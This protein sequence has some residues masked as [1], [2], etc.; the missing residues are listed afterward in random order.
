MKKQK[1]AQPKHFNWIQKFSEEKRKSLQD[2]GQSK[3]T[4]KISKLCK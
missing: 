3:S 1:N 4:I 2:Y